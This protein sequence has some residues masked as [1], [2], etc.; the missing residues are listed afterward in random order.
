M[1]AARRMYSSESELI[2]T[3]QEETG[4]SSISENGLPS[5]SNVLAS[6]ALAGSFQV[7]GGRPGRII[8]AHIHAVGGELTRGRRKD[9]REQDE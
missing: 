4:A 9:C 8:L 7:R 5:V 2:V 3:A 6:Q 1:V